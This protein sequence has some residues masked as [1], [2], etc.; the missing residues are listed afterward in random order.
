MFYGA[1]IARRIG[2][3]VR[4]MFKG[5]PGK[6]KDILR[7]PDYDDPLDALTYETTNNVIGVITICL[8]GILL[9]WLK[10]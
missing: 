5:F 10:L 1:V 9:A 2:A 8:L 4:W 3:F 7:G 6:F